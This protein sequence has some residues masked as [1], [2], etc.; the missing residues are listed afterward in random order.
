MPFGYIMTFESDPPD[1]NLID[2]TFFSHHAWTDWRD[3]HLPM[4]RR[5]VHTYFPADF[6]TKEQW[7]TALAEGR[8]QRAADK[9]EPI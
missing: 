6:R 4:P 3:L 8:R 7:D 9:I 1:P 2:I 5:P